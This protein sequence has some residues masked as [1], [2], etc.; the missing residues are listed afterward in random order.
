MSL[1]AARIAEEP[2]GIRNDVE[3]QAVSIVSK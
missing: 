1:P 3:I 2:A